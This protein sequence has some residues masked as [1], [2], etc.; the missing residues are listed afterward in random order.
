MTDHARLTALTIA[1]AAGLIAAGDLSPRELVEACLA[2]IE[3]LN[4][5]LNAFLS[6]MADEALR[7]AR[8]ASEALARG[9]HWGPLHGIPVAVK[10]LIDVAGEFTTAGSL[11]MGQA[12]AADD[13]DVVRLLRAAGAILIGKTNLHELAIGATS[14]NPHY[15]AVHNPWNLDYSPG[16]SSGGSAAAVAGWLCPAALGTDTGGSIRVPSALCGLTGMRPG[17]GRVSRRGVLPMSW[18]LDTVGPIAHTAYDVALMLDVLDGQPAAPARCLMHLTEPVGGLR[19]GLPVDD[20]FWRET[21]YQVV[22]AVRRAAEVLS[23]LGLLVAEVSLPDVQQALQAASVISLADA[24]AFHEER[25]ARQSQSL[26]ADVRAR[27]EWGANRSGPEYARARQTGRE[28]QAQLLALLRESVDILL[29]PTTPVAAYPLAHSEGLAAARELLRFTY[30]FSLS[31][32]PALNLP[33]GLTDD[34]FPIGCQ[35]IAAGE[36]MLT[37]VAHAYQQAT[38]WHLQRAPLEEA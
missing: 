34:G 22:G 2:R 27:L 29:V 10:D 20:F 17:S 28:W 19:V 12:R 9:E 32:L 4:P 16:G 24:A 14:V 21:D 30:P 26:G 1:H 25:L 33:C 5:A 38:G 37:R 7:E 35:L 6:V 11:L 18:T 36:S 23:D 3:R 15:G 8:H 13:A 31:G